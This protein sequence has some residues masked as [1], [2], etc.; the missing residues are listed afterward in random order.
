MQ[1]LDIV[2][3]KAQGMFGGKAKAAAWLSTPNHLFAGMSEIEFVKDQETL[4]PV[5]EVLVQ[6]EH[7]NL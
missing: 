1:G 7:G 4:E 6:T 2:W 3:K 5:I